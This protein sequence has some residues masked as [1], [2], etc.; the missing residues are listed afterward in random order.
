MKN[1]FLSSEELASVTAVELE[2]AAIAVQIHKGMAAGRRVF[3]GVPVGLVT[4]VERFL[5]ERR[6]V[7]AI[8]NRT[9]DT[10][11]IV[12]SGPVPAIAVT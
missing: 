6:Y 5:V 2:I 12:V 8:R 7:V 10:A 3:S 1:P 11:E 9:E 4:D